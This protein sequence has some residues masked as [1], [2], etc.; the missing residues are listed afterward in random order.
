MRPTAAFTVPITWSAGGCS[1]GARRA[2]ASGAEGSAKNS[3]YVPGVVFIARGVERQ[4]RELSAGRMKGPNVFARTTPRQGHCARELQP[5]RT[6]WPPQPMRRNANHGRVAGRPSAL[7][8]RASQ[9]RHGPPTALPLA[10]LAVA[11]P[12]SLPLPVCSRA[13]PKVKGAWHPP[14][15]IIMAWAAAEYQYL[16]SCCR[17]PRCCS[18]L[19]RD[20]G[21]PFCPHAL[22]TLDCPGALLHV[23]FFGR[24]FPSL[25]PQLHDRCTPH[26]THAPTGRPGRPLTAP[27]SLPSAI[28]SVES[29]R[30]SIPHLHSNPRP[31][32]ETDRV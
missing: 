4:R 31:R 17:P 18:V 12:L 9:R 6:H 23:L 1:T 8:Q 3:L 7:G 14:S 13:L 25:G 21:I 11:R 24:A 28:V 19:Y 15:A 20:D 2:A 30:C 26:P 10:P 27:Q 29:T 16:L 5:Q 22:E 32:R